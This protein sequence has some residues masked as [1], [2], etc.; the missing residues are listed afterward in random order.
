MD[1]SKEGMNRLL[2][3]DFPVY[4]VPPQEW[5]GDVSI[6][7]GYGTSRQPGSV[8]L[9]YD[10]DVIEERP[11]HRIEIESIG[12]AIPEDL[13]AADL[14]NQLAYHTA[15]QNF[16]HPFEPLEERPVKGSEKFNAEMVDGRIVLRTVHLPLAGARGSL[17][18]HGDFDR[19]AF[20][21]YPE[22]RLYRS[23]RGEVSIVMLSWG[24]DDD[25][26]GAF[27]ETLR[28]IEN[29]RA[30]FDA[31]ARRHVASWER[32]RQRRDR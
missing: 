17:E 5:D 14:V 29:D 20:D 32:I 8:R 12:P 26:L 21:E 10:L 22:L 4:A 27:V 3:A 24:F 6:S 30:L 7:G 13:Y 15:I 19:V 28:S 2:N 18:P 16:V 25:F 11:S 31:L 1:I 9:Q 23:R